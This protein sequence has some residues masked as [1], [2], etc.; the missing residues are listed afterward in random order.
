MILCIASLL[1]SP[2]SV[3]VRWKNTLFLGIDACFKL[4][5]KDRG[6]ND[7]DLSTGLAY[8]VNEELYQAHLGANTDVTEPV[9]FTYRSSYQL[10]V[11]ESDKI[12]TYGPDLH[13]VNQAYTKHSQGYAVTGV[14]AVSCRHAF[15]RPKG[16][17]DLQKGEK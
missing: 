4:K 1:Y 7:P 16:V 17:V 12:S 3:V 10:V 15:V 13:A 8:M 2:I 5:L 9:S 6:F 14:A 11:D